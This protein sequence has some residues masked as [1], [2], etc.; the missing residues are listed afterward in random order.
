M[1]KYRR[2]APKLVNPWRPPA[3]QV[4]QADPNILMAACPSCAWVESDGNTG[5]V[6]WQA[7][8]TLA[9]D[10][11]RECTFLTDALIDWYSKPENL[12]RLDTPPYLFGRIMEAIRGDADRA[13]DRGDWETAQERYVPPT[14]GQYQGIVTITR[15]SDPK[16][17]LLLGYLAAL[18]YRPPTKGTD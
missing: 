11:A 5:P 13:L 7:L 17:Q 10:H 9:R 3:M 4:W 6:G 15:P 18:G 14:W 8:H 16:D 12:N 1:T 2:Y